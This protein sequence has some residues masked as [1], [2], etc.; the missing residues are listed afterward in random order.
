[1]LLA[2]ASAISAQAIVADTSS[3]LSA[4]NLEQPN[5][6]ATQ[7]HSKRALQLKVTCSRHN[8]DGLLIRASISNLGFK[9]ERAPGLNPIDYEIVFKDYHSTDLIR[10]YDS[11]IGN[12]APA[13][14]TELPILLPANTLTADFVLPSFYRRVHVSQ[15]RRIRCSLVCR[16][17]CYSNQD[18][19]TSK[20]FQLDSPW[21]DVPVA[22]AK[23]RASDR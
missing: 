23:T 21:T 9:P 12:R 20:R 13:S 3:R 5:W 2:I 22:T 6:F 10:V 18:I 19:T 7:D 4:F 15:E 14:E 1:M 8:K 17:I 16:T 11:R